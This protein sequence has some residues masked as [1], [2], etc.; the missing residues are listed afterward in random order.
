MEE[1]SLLGIQDAITR[2]NRAVKINQ[3]YIKK[4]WEKLDLLDERIK[5]SS[6]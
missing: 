1:E 5:N 4:M 2:I 3:D 6:E